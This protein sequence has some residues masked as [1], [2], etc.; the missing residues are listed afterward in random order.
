[1]TI[2][3]S[4]SPSAEWQQSWML[5]RRALAFALP[6]RQWCGQ[7]RIGYRRTTSDCSDNRITGKD[8]I[9][10]TSLQLRA[11]GAGH[12]LR[13]PAVQPPSDSGRYIPNDTRGASRIWVAAQSRQR[14]RRGGHGHP[15]RP[16]APH[17]AGTAIPRTGAAHRG[18][19]ATAYPRPA[20]SA[21]PARGSPR[22]SPRASPFMTASIPTTPRGGRGR[23]VL[24]RATSRHAPSPIC[25]RGQRP[26]TGRRP[27]A[28]PGHGS[29][30]A[31]FVVAVMTPTNHRTAD[32]W[33]ADSVTTTPRFIGIHGG[34]NTRSGGVLRPVVRSRHK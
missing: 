3:L 34:F 18:T 33:S 11:D 13:G 2:R 31:C 15:V 8:P 28:E 7:F 4:A 22:R 17:G 24:H 10:G 1:M 19:A 16:D 20:G 9:V 27:P 12:P 23:L 14:A 21:R 30:L 29:V 6:K 26:S 5:P 32:P 25:R